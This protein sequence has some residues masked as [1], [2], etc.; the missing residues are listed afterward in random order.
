MKPYQLDQIEALADGDQEFILA[1]IHAFLEEVPEAVQQIQEGL[2]ENNHYKVYQNAHKI[3]PTLS[4]FGVNLQKEI[5]ALQHW[6]EHKETSKNC[7][8]EYTLLFNKI[9][10][11]AKAL[12]QD[13]PL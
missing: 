8:E 5:L 6:G 10:E 7:S 1:I 4:L 11:V 13:Y 3:K 9:T 2:K 12:Q